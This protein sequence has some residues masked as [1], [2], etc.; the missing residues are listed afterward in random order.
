[1]HDIGYAPSI[2][3]ALSSAGDPSPDAASATVR[4]GNQRTQ[5]GELALSVAG[6]AGGGMSDLRLPDLVAR[7]S[8]EQDL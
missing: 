8:P 6:L 2:A 3:E 1:M 4:F 5:L 7:M